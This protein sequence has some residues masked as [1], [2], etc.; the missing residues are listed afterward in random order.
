MRDRTGGG[1]IRQ[2]LSTKL[3]THFSTTSPPSPLP[4][5]PLAPLPLR[6]SPRGAPYRWLSR[7]LP[8]ARGLGWVVIALGT[9]VLPIYLLVFMIALP[10]YSPAEIVPQYVILWATFVLVTAYTLRQSRWSVRHISILSAF[11]LV[12]CSC[13]FVLGGYTHLGQSSVLATSPTGGTVMAPLPDTYDDNDPGPYVGGLAILSW[14]GAGASS[15]VPPS[16]PSHEPPYGKHEKKAW[17]SCCLEKSPGSKDTP[18]FVPTPFAFAAQACSRCRPGLCA[19][20]RSAY[21]SSSP[22]CGW[23][24]TS[25]GSSRWPAS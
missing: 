3:I 1:G 25:R 10:E 22:W 24:P 14:A 19:W 8:T 20:G 17:A 23:W 12:I 4:S 15:R 9:T 11:N 2:G 7:N 16:P 13:A 18:R 6:Q 21:R 5:P